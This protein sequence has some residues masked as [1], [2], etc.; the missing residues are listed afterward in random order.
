MDLEII[1]TVLAVARLKSFSAAAYFIPC[2]QSSVSRRVE[3]AEDELG[4][5]IFLRPTLGTSRNVEL[6]EAGEKIIQAMMRVSEA[7]SELF[8]IASGGDL[9]QTT[10]NIGMRRNMM[11]PM[12]ISLMKADF[13]DEDRDTAISITQDAFNVLLSELWANRLDAVLFRCAWLDETR[14]QVP[15]G[16]HL[17]PLGKM[18]LYVGMS[19]KNPLSGHKN[20]RPEELTKELFLLGEDPSDAVPGVEFSTVR[21]FKQV[22]SESNVPTVKRLS[23][24]VMEVRYKLTMEDRGMIS[25]YTPAPWRVVEGITYLPLV[26]VELNNQFYMIYAEGSKEKQILSFCRFFSKNLDSNDQ[27]AGSPPEQRDTPSGT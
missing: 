21:R 11:A 20:I 18:G 17:L 10:L 19:S 5:S 24:E 23:N 9:I 7:Y 22:F 25:S 13:F 2:S 1:K 8:Y 15:R 4:V 26:D 3:A 27:A 14:F 6:T 16:F 12:G